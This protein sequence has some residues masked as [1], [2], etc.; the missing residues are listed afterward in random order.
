MTDRPA[1]ED[2]VQLVI[3]DL[4]AR[5]ELGVARYGKS[6][7]PTDPEANL[8]EAYEEILDLL[9]YLR[10][11]LEKRKLLDAELAALRA[12]NARLKEQ[13]AKLLTPVEEPPDA[14]LSVDPDDY[15][16]F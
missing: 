15:P 2:C 7:W 3:A 6:L 9:V 16:L 13:W 11:E 5:R 10:G 8:T 12:E 4:T 1:G 14:E